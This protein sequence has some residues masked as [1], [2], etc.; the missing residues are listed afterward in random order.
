MHDAVSST[1]HLLLDLCC[2]NLIFVVRVDDV[3]DA[4]SKPDWNPMG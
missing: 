1:Y 2:Q 4:E 3:V